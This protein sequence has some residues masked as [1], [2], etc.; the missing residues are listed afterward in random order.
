[1]FSVSALF[2]RLCCIM[3]WYK[4]VHLCLWVPFKHCELQTSHSYNFTNFSQSKQSGWE[5]GPWLCFSGPKPWPYRRSISA[6]EVWPMSQRFY[7]PPSVSAPPWKL[8]KPQVQITKQRINPSEV[9]LHALHYAS[10]S[11]PHLK[12]RHSLRRDAFRIL[13]FLRFCPVRI[14]FVMRRARMHAFRCC[15]LL[16]VEDSSM[17]I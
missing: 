8:V 11:E 13:T 10:Y 3:A 5:L 17:L 15:A 12:K 6:Q 7:R 2:W 9:Q 14:W 1:M 16:V 4:E